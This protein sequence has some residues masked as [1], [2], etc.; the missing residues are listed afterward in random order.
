MRARSRGARAIDFAA[1]RVRRAHFSSRV[2]DARIVRT[3]VS[4][5]HYSRLRAAATSPRMAFMRGFPLRAR[6]N[7]QRALIAHAAVQGVSLSVP[8]TLLAPMLDRAT[9]SMA[10]IDD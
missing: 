8:A 10:S 5:R 9:R 4:N 6:T 1:R 2:T 7:N 3:I